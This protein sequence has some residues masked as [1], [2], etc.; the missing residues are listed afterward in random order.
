MEPV[1]MILYDHPLSGN[2]HKVRMLLSMLGLNVETRFID[3]V[4]HAH[5][6][7]GFERLNPLLEIPVLE[8][9]MEIIPD[10][11]AILV[12]LARK[13]GPD[14]FPIDAPDA[15]QVVRW[16]AFAALPIATSLQPARLYHLIGEDGDIQAL[17]ARCARVLAVLDS[18]L[19]CRE[20]LVVRPSIADLACFPYVALCGDARLSLDP[21]PHVKAWVARVKALPGYVGMPGLD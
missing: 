9:G 5:I 1:P 15:A 10:S 13:Y 18:H 20:W 4:N 2:C 17:N 19:A 3:V 21:T 6:G 12:Y 14:W 11:Q 8:D 7:V 16:L